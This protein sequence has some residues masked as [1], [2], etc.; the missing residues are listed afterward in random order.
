MFESKAA[1][2]CECK[3]VKSKQQLTLG[4]STEPPL[5]L[6]IGTGQETREKDLEVHTSGWQWAGSGTRPQSGHY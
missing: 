3:S 2:R 4:K 5:F 6:K 1:K